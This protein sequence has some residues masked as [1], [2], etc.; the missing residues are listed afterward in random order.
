[1]IRKTSILDSIVQTTKVSISADNVVIVCIS[2]C[3]SKGCKVRNHTH[4]GAWS[5]VGNVSV[6]IGGARGTGENGPNA[7]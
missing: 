5:K 7:I 1:M 2:P 3:I 6:S 4:S